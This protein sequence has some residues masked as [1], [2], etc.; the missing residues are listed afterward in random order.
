MFRR[1]FLFHLLML[2]FFIATPAR[3]E[4][5][6]VLQGLDKVTARISTL[7]APLDTEIAFGGLRIIARACYKNPPE[8]TPEVTGFLEIDEA[9]IA[10]DRRRLFSGWM[11][12]SS[13]GLNPLE[14]PVYDITVIDC[15]N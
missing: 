2:A 15:K 10:K 12:A 7:E 6:L 11:F 4:T 5:R 13:P 14:H 8:E 9:P 3:A 1:D